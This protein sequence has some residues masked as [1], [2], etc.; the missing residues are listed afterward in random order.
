MRSVGGRALSP[1]V[2]SLASPTEA[3]LN[4][5]WSADF[6]SR[7]SFAHALHKA[8]SEVTAAADKSKSTRQSAEI[9]R[10]L[11]NP[12]AGC[13]GIMIQAFKRELIEPRQPLR[14]CRRD[15]PSH[16]N[17]FFGRIGLVGHR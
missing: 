8:R 11:P 13:P 10:P 3:Q 9:T 17:R 2:E 16:Q 12:A 4:L 14:R 15:T 5:P 7:R 6:S 1:K